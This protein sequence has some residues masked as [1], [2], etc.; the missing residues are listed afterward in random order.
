[1]GIPQVSA[2]LSASPQSSQLMLCEEPKRA[3][4]SSADDILLTLTNE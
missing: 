1:M 2:Y 4:D 3:L